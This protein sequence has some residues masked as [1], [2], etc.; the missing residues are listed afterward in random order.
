[1]QRQKNIKICD[2]LS[3]RLWSPRR[4]LLVPT[5]ASFPSSYVPDFLFTDHPS[6]R[7][8]QLATSYNNYTDNYHIL[9]AG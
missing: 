6:D 4:L 3:F 9:L 2:S 1:M 8:S 7:T 5:Y